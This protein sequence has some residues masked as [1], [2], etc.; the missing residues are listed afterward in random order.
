MGEKSGAVV[1]LVLVTTFCIVFIAIS[2]RSKVKQGAQSGVMGIWS[3]F[4]EPRPE[5]RAEFCYV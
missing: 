1:F 5:V 3:Y 4:V 2:H